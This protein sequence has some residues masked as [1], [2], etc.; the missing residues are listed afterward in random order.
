LGMGGRWFG[1]WGYIEWMGEG[2]E[3]RVSESERRGE[4]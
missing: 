3:L 4:R 2:G 1:E